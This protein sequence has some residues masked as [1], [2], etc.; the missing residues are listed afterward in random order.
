MAPGNEPV[1]EGLS[2]LQLVGRGGFSTVYRARQER[3]A[4]DV[5][6]KVLH[7]DISDP[8]AREQFHNECAAAGAMANHPNIV[9]VYDS[10]VTASGEPYLVM[11]FCDQGSLADRVRG[12]ALDP[13]TAVTILIKL[14]GA[15]ATA[16]QFGILHRD[17][18][19][20]NVLFTSYGEPALADF[21]VASLTS[22]AQ[23]SFTVAALTPNHA[24]PEVL[25]GGR[26]SAASDVYS[27]A[28]TAYQILTGTPPFQRGRDEGL[29]SFFGRVVREPAPPLVRA[30]VPAGLA[31]AIARGLAKTPERRYATAEAFGHDLRQVQLADGVN[32]TAPVVP[33]SPVDPAPTTVSA[34]VN[35][36]P[37]LPAAPAPVP[38]GVVIPPPPPPGALASSQEGNVT[39]LRPGGRPSVPP[40]PLP[41]PP[42]QEEQLAGSGARRHCRA[43]SALRRGR[44]LRIPAAFRHPIRGAAGRRRHH[45]GRDERSHGF[46]L[47]HRCRH[48]HRHPN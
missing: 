47:H 2:G 14:C 31:S 5:A 48:R 19:P 26:A 28:S 30:D 40:A 25:D 15:L 44:L 34:A 35:A 45:A 33:T 37:A 39:M 36:P 7:V 24:A 16:H 21:G 29:L 42:Q 11:E 1:I 46:R 12:G 32:A 6:V 13:A 38:G 41:A 3:L 22:G 8:R 20:E 17:I 27:L 9:T 43:G 18:K 10:G 23:K 4:R